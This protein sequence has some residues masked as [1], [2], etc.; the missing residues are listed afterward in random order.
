MSGT[1]GRGH[2]VLRHRHHRPPADEAGDGIEDL[3][4]ENAE[5]IY[6]VAFSVVQ[7]RH[8]AEDVV[9]ETI[10]KAWQALPQW[11]GDG[12]RKS[13]VLSI[14]HNTA[15]SYLRRIRDTVQ[16][17]CDFVDAPGG[18][19]VERASAARSDLGRLRVA[20][21]DLD[22]L[23][24]A[25]LVMRDV[26]SMTYQQIVEALDVPLTTVKTRLLRARRELHRVLE[27]GVTT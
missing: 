20:L 23:S 27:S 7:D 10:I 8:L 17:P 11:R 9:Q 4:R 22:D 6:R 14:A 18:D 13:W 3:V 15:V 26:E 5:A 16:P 24:R 25:I 19:D 12:S 21:M 2:R 1:L